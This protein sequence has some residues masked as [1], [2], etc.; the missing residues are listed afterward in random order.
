MSDVMKLAIQVTAVDMLSGIVSRM[1]QSILG[2]G[3]AGKKS[4]KDFDDMTSHITKG[5][6]AI[7]VSAYAL[8]KIKPGVQ[9]AADLQEAMIDVKMSLMRSGQAA[10]ALNDELQQ[11]R[12]TAVNIQAVTPFSAQDVVEIQNELLKAGLDMKDVVGKGGAAWATAAPLPTATGKRVRRTTS[13][14]AMSACESTRP[15]T[16]PALSLRRC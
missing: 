14:T 7:A 6:K 3:E 2:L 1:K 15:S 8:N 13:R 11:V 9:A 5:L 12:S 16:R 10:A 4:Q